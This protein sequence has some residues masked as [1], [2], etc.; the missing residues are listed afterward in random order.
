MTNLKRIIWLVS[1]PKS[2][3]TWVRSLLANY[4]Q[5][6]G[7][8]VGLNELGWFT[9]SDTRQEFFDQAAGGQFAARTVDDWIGVRPRALRLIAA[10][11]E[12]HHFVKSHC[13]LG[14]VNGVELIPPDVTA[15]AVYIMRNPFDVAPSYARHMGVGLDAIIDR[16]TDNLAT[17]GTAS[18]I[19]EITGRWDDHVRN[20]T[21]AQ[22]LPM[23]VM[24]YEDMAAY[25]RLAFQKLI[26]F[27]RLPFD[28]A[29]LKRALSAASFRNLQGQER[30]QG[31]RE[32]PPHMDSFFSSGRPGAW[33]RELTP[34]QVARI[35]AA[36]LPV[37]QKWYP[38]MLAE[39]AAVA[40][41]AEA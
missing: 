41:R 21:Q 1:Y 12:G 19:M 37:L 39:T 38:E 4:F 8:T 24:R 15:A 9:L 5:P 17:H 7:Q 34:A 6:D 25:D 26:E 11:K 33:K 3:N 31:F 35:R 23:H 18:G 28:K 2:G 13:Q 40:E 27:L 10:S 32:R 16:M 29:R 30:D 20:W 14:L 36:F 22:G